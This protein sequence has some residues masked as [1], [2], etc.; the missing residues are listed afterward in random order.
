MKR[1][2]PPVPRKPARSARAGTQKKKAAPKR[3][4]AAASA[5]DSGW[6]LGPY[7]E[8]ISKE[9]FASAILRPGDSQ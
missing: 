8:I 7:G 5:P 9:D 3:A 1:K 2:Q 6:V 4:G